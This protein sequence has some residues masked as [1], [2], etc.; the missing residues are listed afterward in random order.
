MEKSYIAQ[1]N[2]S[3]NSVGSGFIYTAKDHYYIFTA[4][5]VLCGESNEYK[6]NLGDII[7]KYN[8]QN[9]RVDITED[10]VCL[11]G[12]DID[13]AIIAVAKSKLS[14]IGKTPLLSQSSQVDINCRISG[15]PKARGNEN[16]LSIV[17]GVIKCD[18]DSINQ[19]QLEVNDPVVYNLEADPLTEGYSGSGVFYENKQGTFVLAL[20]CGYNN[21]IK[22]VF[23]VNWNTVNTMLAQYTLPLVAFNN[24]EF[25][26]TILSDIDTLSCNSKSLM[27]RLNDKIG[28]IHL[29]RNETKSVIKESI[30]NNDVVIIYGDAGT[31]KSAIA[32]E[33]I[34]EYVADES[35]FVFAVKADS[36]DKESLAHMSNSF[37]LKNRMDQL[38][39]SCALNDSSILYIDSAEQ[40]LEIR[41]WDTVID[42]INLITSV[43]KFK[44]VFSTRSYSVPYIQTRLSYITSSSAS[45]KIDIITPDEL[46]NIA[47]KYESAR[48][49]QKNIR[50]N[51]I[52]RVPFY[53][54]YITRI[55]SM[56]L[57][58]S[59]ISEN[60]FRELLWEYIVEGNDIKNSHN[61]SEAFMTI[62]MLRASQMQPFA[63]INGIDV[64]REILDNL[65]RN[66]LIVKE[67]NNER[68]APAH[69][70]LEDLALCRH[71][72]SIYND[73]QTTQNTISFYEN[74]GKEPSVRRAYRLW[75]TQKIEAEQENCKL[76]IEYTLNSETHQYWKDE[77]LLVVLRSNFIK[78]LLVEYCSMLLSDNEKL[79]RRCLLLMKVACKE[80]DEEV[81]QL[82][83]SESKEK[84]SSM[85]FLKPSGDI[86]CMMTKFIFEHKDE[87]DTK[88]KVYID[89][90]LEWSGKI[91]FVRKSY[92]IESRSIGLLIVDILNSYKQGSYN[93]YKQKDLIL[94]LYKLSGVVASEANELI[95]WAIENKKSYLGREIISLIQ[96]N[97]NWLVP[98]KYIHKAVI[99]ILRYSWVFIEEEYQKEIAKSKFHFQNKSRETVYGF[100]EELS[101]L[102]MGAL[103]TPMF[104]LLDNHP[105]DGIRFIVELLNHSINEL[106]KDENLSAELIPIVF[107]VN[108]VTYSQKGSER[109]WCMYRGGTAECEILSAILMALEKVLL[110]YAKYCDE[111]DWVRQFV[112]KIFVY[113]LSNCRNVASTSIIASVLMAYP[114]CW[115]DKVFSLLRVKEFY[116]WDLTRY[117]HEI[118]AKNYS[119]D[120]IIAKE[121]IESNSLPHRK[122]TL[123]GFILQ[124]SFDESNRQKCFDIID[125]FIANDDRSNVTWS[126][127]LEHMDLRKQE[128][129]QIAENK[130]MLQT[131][132]TPKLA[133]HIEDYNK[134]HVDTFLN[135][136]SVGNWTRSV[137]KGESNVTIDEWKNKLEDVIRNKNNMFNSPISFA[138]VG[139]LFLWDQ[140]CDKHKDWCVCNIKNFFNN[141]LGDIDLLPLIPSMLDIVK[142]DQYIDDVKTLILQIV[143]YYQPEHMLAGF[144]SS[145]RKHDDKDTMLFYKSCIWGVANYLNE[146][147]IDN[148]DLKTILSN[149]YSVIPG[150]ISASNIN[151]VISALQMASNEL[152]S[153]DADISIAIN[154]VNE[155]ICHE[156]R[157]DKY[158]NQYLTVDSEFAFSVIYANYVLYIDDTQDRL[159][160][161]SALIEGVYNIVN[162]DK[163]DHQ[164]IIDYF[165]RIMYEMTM[166]LGAEPKLYKNFWQLWN[167]L[168]SFS[169]EK[170]TKTFCESLMFK[171]ICTYP[172]EIEDWDGIRG[173]RLDV[174]ACIKFVNDPLLAVKL[175]RCCG[176]DELLPYALP[177]IEYILSH[178]IRKIDDCQLFLEKIAHRLFSDTPKRIQIKSNKT[179]SDSFVNILDILINNGSAKSFI[180]R[181]DFI[182]TLAR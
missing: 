141:S 51:S 103:G 171:K 36:L 66:G 138:G 165:D 16:I 97:Q 26:N 156:M 80:P 45:H 150:N 4:K 135:S 113:I 44:I 117:S 180:I 41:H 19:I 52:L 37:G 1:I 133:E 177:D 84:Y 126:I 74:I 47:V 54:D 81:M 125:D 29:D 119:T 154:R 159:R 31:G 30:R 118:A 53:L 139:I 56:K 92:P 153:V 102:K 35:G 109:L 69:D 124:L 57:V 142:E 18:S 39:M 10:V 94:I 161:F 14:N 63:T 83:N 23:G 79:L 178:N 123:R 33:V 155:L 11:G 134:F 43:G 48:V 111:Y 78:S 176:Y 42:F 116:Q 130:I 73:W 181:D 70:I 60:D 170:N 120:I 115:G 6:D 17:Q 131:K 143:V 3:N 22:R 100:N 9:Y 137:L 88:D 28:D 65:V 128:L 15:Y 62:A 145:L 96:E 59:D 49:L 160:T 157:N 40:L 136:I 64:N 144:Y 67:E 106:S 72:N 114:K 87:I 58:G 2:T 172:Y 162:E 85:E 107:D 50:I 76:F 13:L 46:S 182:A 32:K 89:F 110:D 149:E 146:R 127:A 163:F 61:R 55:E 82:V 101:I 5:H 68:Y 140:L 174:S 104:S 95:D 21:H 151:N 121:R 25:D 112:D 147:Q 175:L 122:E 166:L 71:I 7:I 164:P 86:W 12:D 148:K 158:N 132:H 75:A 173:K 179:Y 167:C 168:F 129:T 77:L 105:W 93:S 34:D 8:T 108:G 99:N 152:L 24:I 98:C 38:L 90:I 20:M 169:K 91:G 27:N